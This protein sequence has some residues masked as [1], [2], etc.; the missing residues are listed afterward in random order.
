VAPSIRRMTL[1][2]PTSGGRSVGIV[3]SWT[4]ATEFFWKHS[5]KQLFDISISALIVI[6]VISSV[7]ENRRPLRTILAAEKKNI[8]VGD[9]SG[10]H[11][12]C[13]KAVTLCL[14]TQQPVGRCV[15][16][17][18]QPAVLCTFSQTLPSHYIPEAKEDFDANFYA[19]SMPTPWPE[20]ASEPYRP[21][22]RRL[23]ANLVPTFPDRGYHVVSE[24]DP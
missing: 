1:T 8:S 13:S 23:S 5:W 24:T 21:S 3:R 7:L 22:D 2:S 6:A 10:E 4:Q 9:K 14:I 17:Q 12:G 19:Y 11:G 18:K 15:L 20:S 16:V